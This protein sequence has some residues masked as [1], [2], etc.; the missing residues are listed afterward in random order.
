MARRRQERANF[1]SLINMLHDQNDQ[2]LQAQHGTTR[3][4]VSL[5]DYLF[6]QDRAE[7]RA[8]L[9]AEMEAK[10]QE[11]RSSSGRGTS[12]G[13]PVPKLPRKGLGGLIASFLG[14]S[15][16]GGKGFN[17]LKALL[18]SG[19]IPFTVP[20]LFVRGLLGAAVIPSII[21]AIDDGQVIAD[22]SG[23]SGI[24]SAISAFLTG[25]KDKAG[26]TDIASL[27]QS[28]AGGTIK[29]A[30]IAAM[31]PGLGV[32]GVLIAAAI[33]GAASGIATFWGNDRTAK[34]LDEVGNIIS[35]FLFGENQ[36]V[37]GLAIMG[38]GTTA[39]MMKVMPS[40]AKFG[41]PGMLAGAVVGAGL[42]Y[43]TKLKL[44][45]KDNKTIQKEITD[46][47]FETHEDKSIADWVA[48]LG[49]SHGASVWVRRVVGSRGGIHGI[50][51]SLIAYQAYD[52]VNG[53]TLHYQNKTVA[54]S[55][56]DLLS[57]AYDYITGMFTSEVK[58]E[59]HAA[60][61]M[62]EKL[63][64]AKEAQK[65][66]A[67][68]LTQLTEGSLWGGDQKQD[69]K[70]VKQRFRDTELKKGPELKKGDIEK[71]FKKYKKTPEYQEEVAITTL[72][73]LLGSDILKQ[74]IS[75]QEGTGA[76]RINYKALS[77]VLE[78]PA[79][80]EKLDL[81]PGW[82][83]KLLNDMSSGI[84]RGGI[85][86]EHSRLRKAL[87]SLHS[88]QLKMNKE[89]E[90]DWLRGTQYK[91]GPKSKIK[92]EQK[93]APV[94]D[95]K[96]GKLIPEDT[97]KELLALAWQNANM[98]KENNGTSMPV[99]TNTYSYQNIDNITKEFPATSHLNMRTELLQ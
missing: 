52:A 74:F 25:N 50:F 40:F 72:N 55:I 42:G 24:S 3:A 79:I 51:A 9:E 29:G 85:G 91:K 15:L 56:R 87:Q 59:I 7:M 23:A 14:T 80:R 19:K 45:G 30:G 26:K 92:L 21:K 77:R 43:F 49:L 16:L 57:D 31:I 63:Q 41:L 89:T 88:D 13:I 47:L 46:L 4:I 95:K 81:N 97:S 65:N 48:Q 44:E 36:I 68:V 33:G 27:A 64:M 5:N 37:T 98:S 39:L 78:D 82:A 53:V 99:F 66:R 83:E 60:R 12:G 32:R 75:T 54:N 69:F 84:V 22:R 71:S 90:G 94:L 61:T 17:L 62:A 11:T 8:Q 1:E 73:R 96:T 86:T 38:A 20:K 58:E 70:T 10:D 6:Q 35:K 28:I 18:P 76:L 67:E 34:N 2:Q 93:K